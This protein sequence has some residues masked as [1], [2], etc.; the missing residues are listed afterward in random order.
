M[1]GNIWYVCCPFRLLAESNGYL[2]RAILHDENTYPDSERSNPH[3]FLHP[4]GSL[5][6][7]VPRSDAAFGFGRRI[8]SGR[9]FAQRALWMAVAHVLC[10]F[11]IE[12]AVDDYGRVIEPSGEFGHGFL[13]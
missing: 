6:P 1:V 7:S 11:D 2:C 3:R 12:K 8:Y 4:D 9:H 13:I 10:V 5:N